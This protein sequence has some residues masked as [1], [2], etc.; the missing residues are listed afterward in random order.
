[1]NCK[2]EQFFNWFRLLFVLNH[3]T[4]NTNK[5]G[6]YYRF[7]VAFFYLRILWSWYLCGIKMI[8]DQNMCRIFE[9]NTVCYSIVWNYNLFKFVKL[10]EQTKVG[11]SKNQQN[12]IHLIKSLRCTLNII[13]QPSAAFYICRR[14]FHTFSQ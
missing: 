8:V 7:T 10:A 14:H 4:R 5:T 11:S 6:F 3:T 12:F 2:F 9:T 1:M 13:V